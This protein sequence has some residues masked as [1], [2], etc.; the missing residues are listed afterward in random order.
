MSVTT[1]KVPAAHVEAIRESL[2]AARHDLAGA[3]TGARDS[4]TAS[5]S[6]ARVRL[7]ELDDLVAQIDAGAHAAGASRDLTGPRSELWAAAYDAACR[8]AERVLDDCNEYW[9]GAIAAADV[10]ARIADLGAR[11]ELVDVLGPPPRARP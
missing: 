1:I 9:R 3:M 5:G 4:S 10:R 7:A 6:A 2:A 11:F 8:A